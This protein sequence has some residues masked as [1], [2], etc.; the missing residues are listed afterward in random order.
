MFCEMS[1]YEQAV[2]EEF[3]NAGLLGLLGQALIDFS[4]CNM[5]ITSRRWLAASASWATGKAIH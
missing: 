5:S 4:T 3:A 1:Y 2:A